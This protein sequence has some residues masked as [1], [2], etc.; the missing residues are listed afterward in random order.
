MSL[1]LAPEAPPLVQ[2]ADGTVRVSGTRVTLDIFLTAHRL[3][4]TAADLA[5]EFHTLTLAD[6]HGVLAYVHRHPAEVEAYLARREAEAEALKALILANQRPF[7][8]R[9]ELLARKAAVD[10]ARP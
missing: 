1:T 3:G 4:A 2:S 7:P 6:I 10:A 8:S 9:D 5:D